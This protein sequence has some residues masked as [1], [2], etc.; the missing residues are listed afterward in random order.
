MPRIVTYPDVVLLSMNKL[1]NITAIQPNV[2]GAKKRLLTQKIAYFRHARC[3]DEISFM[4]NSV[5]YYPL[6]VISEIKKETLS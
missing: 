1:S 3:S 6:G 4:S 2:N 5:E